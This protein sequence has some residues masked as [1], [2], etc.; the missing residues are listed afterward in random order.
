MTGQIESAIEEQIPSRWQKLLAWLT[1][2][3]QAMA[4]DPQEHT[5]ATIRQLRE[6]VARLETRVIELEER[7]ERTA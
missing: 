5:D 4:Y 1:A 6:E 7:N 2:F 3:E